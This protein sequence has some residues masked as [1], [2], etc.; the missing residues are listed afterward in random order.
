MTTSSRSDDR[1]TV[2]G[3]IP[4]KAGD[5]VRSMDFSLNRTLEIL[6]Q[7]PYTL[8]RMLT[9]LSDDW[10]R[11]GG[12]EEDWTPYDVIGHLI[13]AEKTDWIPRAEVIRERGE[14]RRFP[15]FDRLAQFSED[16][17]VPLEDRLRE[18]AHLRNTNLER[19]VSWELSDEDLNAQGIHPEFGEVKLRQ[20]L[21]T[22]AVH[23]LTH[24]RQIA[25]FLANRYADAVGPWSQYLSII[26]K[27]PAPP[28]S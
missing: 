5:T 28:E 23:D 10:T 27:N 8:E 1:I 24:I 21:A 9:G 7:T 6:R 18:F 14:D 26:H 15:P 3:L 11:E 2:N 25:T 22:W 13:H 4:T 16:P 17:N 12:S 19:L 20:L